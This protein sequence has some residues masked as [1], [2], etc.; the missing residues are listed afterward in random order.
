MKKIIFLL[1]ILTA[2]SSTEEK[3]SGVYTRSTSYQD[4]LS[5]SLPSQWKKVPGPSADLVLENARSKSMFIFISAC[6]KNEASSLSTLSS[7]LISGLDDIDITD[8]QNIEH[9]GRA[10]IRSKMKASIDGVERH[11]ILMTTQKNNCIYDYALISSSLNN[12]E[13]DTKD[14]DRFI[15]QIILN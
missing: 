15:E 3:I 9:Q 6:R 4:Q 2:C 10:A 8:S 1:F 13:K 14:Y 5:K 7:S 11:F 12:L